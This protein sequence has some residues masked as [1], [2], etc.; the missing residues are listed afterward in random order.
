MQNRYRLL[1]LIIISIILFSACR[2]KEASS[3]KVNSIVD[4]VNDTDAAGFGIKQQQYFKDGIRAEYPVIISG[5]SEKDMEKL[6]GLIKT[7]FD[8]ILGL[9]SFEPFP[10]LT[11]VPTGS[12]VILNI[13]NQV[14]SNNGRL[15]SFLYKAGYNSKYSAHPTE[16]VYTTNLDNRKETRLRLS[17]I[18][19][20]NPD[21][22]KYFKTWDF[23][24]NKNEN[25]EIN[26]AIKQ[27]IKD[28]NEEDLLKGFEAADL[29]GSENHWG[30]FSYLTPDGLGIS[31]SV[32]NFLGDH[33]EF[34]KSY[35]ELK[36]YLKQD[37]S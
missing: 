36:D 33:V 15:I 13:T 19:K 6:N 8:K 11:P 32:P 24:P 28:F 21:F 4:K 30:I 35:S 2:Y 3:N 23:I 17:D 34:E 1:C 5:A 29:I 18:V 9:Y 16:L 26:Y 14:K 27:Y 10:E 20:L 12:T 31:I 22:V 7:D 37:I 25:K